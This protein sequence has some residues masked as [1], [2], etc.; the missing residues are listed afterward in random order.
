MRDAN[1]VQRFVYCFLHAWSADL[2]YHPL[3]FDQ[4]FSK[5]IDHFEYR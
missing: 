1:A 2:F 5:E 4:T 3:C